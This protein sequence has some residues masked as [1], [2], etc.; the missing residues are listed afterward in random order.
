MFQAKIEVKPANIIAS[1]MAL[2]FTL[3]KMHATL[4]IQV[5]DK[6]H[7]V[8]IQIRSKLDPNRMYLS[9]MWIYNAILR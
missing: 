5:S 3:L 6:R 9:L 7:C 1:S 4:L 2:E 8:R